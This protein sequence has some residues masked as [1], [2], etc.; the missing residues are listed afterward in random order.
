MGDKISE[1]S[2][3]FGAFRTYVAKGCE[4]LKVIGHGKVMA[5][6]LSRRT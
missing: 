4:C 6:D 3:S 2:R 1:T 5:Y